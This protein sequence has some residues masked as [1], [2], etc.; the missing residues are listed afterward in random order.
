VTFTTRHRFGRRPGLLIR[1]V[2]PSILAATACAPVYVG[3]PFQ[4]GGTF[5]GLSWREGAPLTMRLEQSGRRLSGNLETAYHL[6]DDGTRVSPAYRGRVSG[7]VVEENLARLRIELT[8]GFDGLTLISDDVVA[9][10]RG[11]ELV[12]EVWSAQVGGQER[13]APRG[14]LITFRAG[15]DQPAPGRHAPRVLGVSFPARI[16]A[17]GTRVEGRIHFEDRDGDVQLVRVSVVQGTF[18]GFSFVPGVIGQTRGEILFTLFAT[19]VQTVRLQVA[20]KD[21]TG[22]ESAP[23]V[24]EFRGE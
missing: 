9:Y 14:P 12:V 1:L 16:P 15:R 6:Q 24:F 7:D 21:A 20:L 11:N 10:R 4:F 22:R 3:Q 8:R 17:D 2:L 19:R 5:E 18:Q 13:R 23:H